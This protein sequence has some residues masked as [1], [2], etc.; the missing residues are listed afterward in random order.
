MARK[1][2]ATLTDLRA[3]EEVDSALWKRVSRVGIVT[4]HGPKIADAMESLPIGEWNG[5]IESSRGRYLIRVIERH[6]AVY[7]AAAVAVQLRDRTGMVLFEGESRF[8][9]ME[10]EGD[11]E[12][13]QTG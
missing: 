1:I 10:I 5:P 9:G 13:L 12:I 6:P 8:G 2:A 3:G 11:T 4:G 7:E